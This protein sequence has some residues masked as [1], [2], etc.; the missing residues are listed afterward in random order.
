MNY[1]RPI[2]RAFTL[3][4][5]AS[6]RWRFA[7][8][9]MRR[10]AAVSHFRIFSRLSRSV[11][12]P[13]RRMAKHSRLRAQGQIVLLSA[14]GGWPVDTHQ[15]A[16]WQIR[17]GLVTRRQTHRVLQP[18]QH[19]GGLSVGRNPASSNKFSGRWR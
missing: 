6:Y 13:S 4:C 2:L 3:V 18:G 7:Q 16:R 14:A 11:S 12:L 15:H 19:L 9:R 17:S 1:R 10:R 5:T 8:K